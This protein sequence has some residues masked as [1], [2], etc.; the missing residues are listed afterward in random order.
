[1]TVEQDYPVAPSELHEHWASVEKPAVGGSGL[2]PQRRSRRST[3]TMRPAA[4][5]SP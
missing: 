1:M 5:P 2:L 3:S 4:L